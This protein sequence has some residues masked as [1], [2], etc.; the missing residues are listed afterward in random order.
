MMTEA[1]SVRRLTGADWQVWRAL[2]LEALKLYPTAFLTTYAEAEAVPAEIIEDRLDTGHTYGVFAAGTP[3][4]IASFIPEMRT[5]TRHR[6]EMGGLFVQPD[7]HGSGAADALMA[8]VIDAAAAI[9]VWQIELYVAADNARAIAFY[10]RHGFQEVGRLPN[11]TYVDGQADTDV[12]MV[13]S[14]PPT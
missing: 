5:Q 8:G 11:A 12:I 9:G 7:L 14:T 6:A 1:L 10:T 2:R 3:V 13:R 4:G